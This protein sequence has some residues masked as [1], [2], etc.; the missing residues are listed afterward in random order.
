MMRV[1][2]RLA[3][4][5]R[6]APRRWTPAARRLVARLAETGGVPVKELMAD[7]DAFLDRA[8]LAGM[9]GTLPD[10][11]LFAGREAG[12]PA[13]ALLAEVEGDMA[14]WKAAQA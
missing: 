11:C 7:T 8:E 12:L 9:A 6:A 10:S 1:G 2:H 4:L 3:T 14:A 5:E 13:E